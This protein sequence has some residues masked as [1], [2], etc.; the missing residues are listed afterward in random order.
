[1]S[2]DAISPA[3]K[4]PSATS[5]GPRNETADAGLSSEQCR[6][7]RGLLDWSVQKLARHAGVPVDCVR[8]FERRRNEGDADTV[9]LI[10]HAL[11]LGG[12][13]FIPED[14]K[15]A[16]ARLRKPSRK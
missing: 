14:K 4:Q 7:A 1:M 3:A 13:E 8:I 5:Q 11:E 12:I 9:E 15:G 2:E 6:A 16:G 10:R